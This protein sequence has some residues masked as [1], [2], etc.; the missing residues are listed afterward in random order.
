MAA[1]LATGLAAWT[2]NEGQLLLVVMVTFLV[3][4]PRRFGFGASR[5]FAAG[6]ALPLAVLAWFKWSLAPPNNLLGPHAMD[7]AL[8]RVTDETRWAML[9]DRTT[10]MLQAWGGTRV[11]ALLILAV[12]AALIAQP[13]RLAGAR[14]AQ[15]LL[16]SAALM[17]GYLVV[18][19]IAPTSLDTMTWHVSTS[20]DRLVTQLWPAAVWSFFQLSGELEGEA[21]SARRVVSI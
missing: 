4:F 17:A 15:G 3:I 1:G 13:A 14:M 8:A 20:F 16:L 18:Y 9:L 10:G 12:T 19:V 21:G 11:S 6:A 7:G 2:K 5:H